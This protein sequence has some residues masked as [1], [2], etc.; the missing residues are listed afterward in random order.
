M[1]ARMLCNFFNPFV[2]RLCLVI[3][4]VVVASAKTAAAD[5]VMVTKTPPIPYVSPSYNWSGFYAGGH[6]GYAWG[7]SNWTASSPGA[8]SVSGSLNLA[9]PIDIFSEAGSFFAGLQAGYNYMLPNRFVVGAEVD[10]SFPSFPTQA[11]ISIGGTSNVASPTL[12]AEAYSETTLASG[13]LRGRVGYA[14]GSWLFY[15]TG[16]FAWTYDRLTLTQLGRRLSLYARLAR[17]HPA[18]DRSRW[19]DAEG[20]CRYLSVRRVADGEPS[21]AVGRTLLRRRRVRHQ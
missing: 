14:P 4:A 11:G 8:P 5:G 12:G 20:R 13:T 1:L 15:A 10:A 2:R 19:R 9:E 18:N 16:G 6:L 21:G 17:F 3:S 7:S